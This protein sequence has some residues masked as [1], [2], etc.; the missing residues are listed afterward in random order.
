MG[1]HRYVS[2]LSAVIAG[3]TLPEKRFSRR[4]L[5]RNVPVTRASRPRDRTGGGAAYSST[6]RV[7]AVMLARIGPVKP[8][9]I[10]YL[11]AHSKACGRA[12]NKPP[13]RSHA[14][15]LRRRRCI[16][17]EPRRAKGGAHE[18]E[19]G[20][21]GDRRRHAAGEAARAEVPAPQRARSAH[22]SRPKDRTGGGA[23]YSWTSRVS[24]VMLPR[25]GPV[26]LFL[27]N[28]LIAHSEAAAPK[29]NRPRAAAALVQQRM[30]RIGGEPR[31]GDAHGSERG[32]RGDRRR[33]SSD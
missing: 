8:V 19:G 1:T 6:S 29:M 13:S 12:E 20:Q 24:A 17:G 32:Q 23:A 28:S 5:R 10:K 9:L 18:R 15:A 21:R 30:H 16:G 33:H 2:A 3:G 14:L 26:K 27:Y 25:I 31:E 4:F 22:A 11:I 7:S